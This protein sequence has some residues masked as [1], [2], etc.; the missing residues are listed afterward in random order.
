MND[1]DG[2]KDRLD[3]VNE[4]ID[5]DRVLLVAVTKTRSPEEINKVIELG[6]TDIGENKVQELVDK[7]DKIDPVRWHMI[8]HLQTNKVKYIIDKVALIHSV[9]SLRLAK[10]IDKR[11]GQKDLIMNI[12]IQ[13]N[14]ALED[15]KHGAQADDTGHLMKEILDECENIK[16]RGL[17][18]MVPFTDDPQEVRPY[19]ARMKAMY[20]SLKTVDHERADFKYLSMG[21]SGDYE[22]A[23]EEGANL[24][25]IGSSIFGPRSY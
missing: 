18:A 3:K 2:I 21:M 25:R 4:S 12:L 15:S 6:V 5:K 9:D 17:M 11:A 19:F 20:D 13:V 14:I 1:I 24:V 16:V 10:E 23:M 7:Y 22:V 8:G